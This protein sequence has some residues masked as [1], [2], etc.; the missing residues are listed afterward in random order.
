MLQ[1]NV[2]PQF[3][4]SVVIICRQD[5]QLHG[6]KQRHSEIIRV[7]CCVVF[8]G[9]LLLPRQQLTVAVLFPVVTLEVVVVCVFEVAAGT[10][11]QLVLLIQTVLTE[12]N[13]LNP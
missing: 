12:G 1:S 13:A 7:F 9:N 5:V 11:I 8:H 4:V 10:V 2:K 6:Q 3:P